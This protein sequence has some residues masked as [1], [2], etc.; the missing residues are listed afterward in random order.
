MFVGVVVETFYKQKSIVCGEGRLTENQREY[1][2]FIIMGYQAK[3]L[4][5]LKADKEYSWFRNTCIKIVAHSLFEAFI[6][7]VIVANT[8]LLG[9]AWYG[10]SARTISIEEGINYFFTSVY[11]IEAFL[12]IGAMHKNYFKEP[13]NVFDFLNVTLTLVVVIVGAT[14]NSKGGVA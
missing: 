9:V 5:K 14:M 10:M 1:I 6:V 2:N 11:F 4:L 12:K 8:V 3:P 7:A 13:W